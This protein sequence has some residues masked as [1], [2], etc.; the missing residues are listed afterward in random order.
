MA[1]LMAYIFGMKQ[2]IHNCANALETTS[3]LLHCLKMSWTLVHKRL[4]GMFAT[5]IKIDLVQENH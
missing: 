3:G 4:N 2:D 1:T 5:Q